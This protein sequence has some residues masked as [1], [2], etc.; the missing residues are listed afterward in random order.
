MSSI[1][2]T[3]LRQWRFVTSGER[4]CFACGS[5]GG[6][7]ADVKMSE[8]VMTQLAKPI[9][10]SAIR[11]ASRSQSKR[12][13]LRET[14]LQTS[15]WKKWSLDART[16]R[17]SR[18]KCREW[19]AAYEFSRLSRH[20]RFLR[21]GFERFLLRR[22]E[23]PALHTSAEQSRAPT[24]RPLSTNQQCAHPHRRARS[25]FHRREIWK[26]LPKSA[27][28]IGT[29]HRPVPRRSRTAQRHQCLASRSVGYARKVAPSLE[30]PRARATKR[31]S[32][33]AWK[34]KFC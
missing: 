7:Q 2:A 23:R 3:S 28:T 25:S 24:R 32:T 29:P 33:P 30:G 10:R 16:H 31:K 4:I 8:R 13:H 22:F 15:R 14:C 5:V 26:Y 19:Y 9:A 12:L 21:R 1:W 20:S 6:Y 27:A 34:R 17:R 18:Q 11:F